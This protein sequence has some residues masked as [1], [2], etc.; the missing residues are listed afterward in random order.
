MDASVLRLMS[1][2]GRA[3]DTGQ[4]VDLLKEFGRLTLAVVGSLAYG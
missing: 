3:A 1:R 4:E 2:L